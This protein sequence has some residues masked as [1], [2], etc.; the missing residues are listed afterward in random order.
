MTDYTYAILDSSSVVTNV[1]ASDNSDSIPVLR[2]L[3][4]DAA[5]IILATD[6]TGPAYISGDLFN[7]KFRAP[8]PFPSW[9]WDS[10][11]LTWVAPVPYP[12]DPNHPYSWDE[13][14]QQWVQMPMP[15]TE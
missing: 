15:D 4:P 12:N 5:D 11:N 6:E 3:I 1:V 13:A 2:L 7:G 8:K 14:S 9:I 10:V